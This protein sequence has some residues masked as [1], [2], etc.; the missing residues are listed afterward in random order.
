M[1]YFIHLLRA[2][3]MLAFDMT[4]LVK[5]LPKTLCMI[6]TV[7]L[8]LEQSRSGV[9]VDLA[10]VPTSLYAVVRWVMLDVSRLLSVFLVVACMTI[11]VL[12][13][14]VVCRVPPS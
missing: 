12:L 6:W 11:L 7:R 1:I 3:R 2:L 13:G 5:L 9:P 14:R 4:N 10:P 8:G